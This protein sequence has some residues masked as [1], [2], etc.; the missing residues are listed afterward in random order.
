MRTRD[1]S[2][3]TLL[4]W[5]NVTYAV[6]V[7]PASVYSDG[8][9][10]TTGT[11]GGGGYAKPFNEYFIG[12]FF[13]SL[14][15]FF[16]LMTSSGRVHLHIDAAIRIWTEMERSAC[17][18]LL[19]LKINA[20]FNFYVPPPQALCNERP[21]AWALKGSTQNPR[22]RLPYSLLKKIAFKSVWQK[23]EKEL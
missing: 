22:K 23:S 7:I 12:Q 20:T 11:G 1:E 17:R 18:L 16:Y 21:L 6:R 4:R 15:E 3:E 14:E 19:F 10:I 2:R 5:T 9:A 13:I 8:S